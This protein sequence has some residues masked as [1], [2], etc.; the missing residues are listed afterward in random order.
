[1][2]TERQV[3]NSPPPPPVCATRVGR[4]IEVQTNA[5]DYSRFEASVLIGCDGLNHPE[6]DLRIRHQAVV[7]EE[8]MLTNVTQRRAMM[9]GGGGNIEGH[10]VRGRC[11][12]RSSHNTIERALTNSR[13]SSSKRS[14]A[15]PD[16]AQPTAH[17]YRRQQ[18]RRPS[19]FVC[20]APIGAERAGGGRRWFRHHHRFLLRPRAWS[21][22]QGG[23]HSGGSRCLAR[24]CRLFLLARSW[25]RMIGRV[26]G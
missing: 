16:P 17:A 7:G 21:H 2:G 20:R 18:R 15:S 10:D 19:S 22:N 5:S 26:G 24:D 13:S 9:R 8:I 3:E 14:R 25:T 23:C 4:S 1:M 12:N 6:S 11:G